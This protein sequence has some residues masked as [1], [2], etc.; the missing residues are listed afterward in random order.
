MKAAGWRCLLG[1]VVV[2]AGTSAAGPV[3][4]RYSE[5]ELFAE[6]AGIQPGETVWL[7]LA[8]RLDPGW[9]TYWLN[10]GDSGMAPRLAW[11]LPEGFSAGA[12]QAPPPSRFESEGLVSLGYKDR[13]AFLVPITAPAAWGGGPA[14]VGLKATWLVCRDLCLPESATFALELNGAAAP[15]PEGLF[16]EARSKLPAPP[17]G[18][19][20]RASR[21]DREVILAAEPPSGPGAESPVAFFPARADEFTYDTATVLQ[22]G[23]TVRLKVSP[24]A[25]AVPARLTGVLF[26]HGT[27]LALDIPIEASLETE[28]VVP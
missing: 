14:T 16:A 12:L 6:R 25:E 9:H 4:A 21:R 13:V 20:L 22:K 28:G 15:G 2:A 1:A 3:R 5:A 27:A 17:D 24:L 26:A 19:T 18:W 23:P 7:A 8:I 10:P 11:N